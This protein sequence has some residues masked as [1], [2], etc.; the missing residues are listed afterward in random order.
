MHNVVRWRKTALFGRLLS[1]LGCLHGRDDARANIDGAGARH[2]GCL[3]TVMSTSS[4][5]SDP[6]GFPQDS[7]KVGRALS[8]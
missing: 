6:R 8:H 2:S 1:F 3:L 5:T 4:Q 7:K